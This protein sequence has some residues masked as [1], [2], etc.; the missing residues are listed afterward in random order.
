M[1]KI[2]TK[3]IVGF[4]LIAILLELI[5]IAWDVF[6]LFFDSELSSALKML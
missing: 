4:I 2:K 3:H 5:V 1:K 6:S